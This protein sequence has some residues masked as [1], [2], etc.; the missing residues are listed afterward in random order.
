MRKRDTSP[1]TSGPDR[2]A[3]PTRTTALQ[4]IPHCDLCAGICKTVAL[5]ASQLAAHRNL[6]YTGCAC[7][8]RSR[9]GQVHRLPSG[10]DSNSVVREA[11]LLTPPCAANKNKTTTTF[12]SESTSSSCLLLRLY[13]TYGSEKLK[14][15]N[16]FE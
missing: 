16:E 10:S 14:N 8:H 11:T 4:E 7:R 15:H 3:G 12:T 2:P 6:H 9:I 5:P 13:N 1:L